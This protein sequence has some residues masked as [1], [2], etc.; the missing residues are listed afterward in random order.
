[1]LSQADI[2][3]VTDAARG[4][5]LSSN[6]YVDVE[7]NTSLVSTVVDFQMQTVAVEKAL[8]HYQKN[9]SDRLFTMGDLQRVLDRYPDTK[10]PHL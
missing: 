5:P 8:A 2:G 3:R 9:W 7:L 1:M 4:V 10:A 6:T